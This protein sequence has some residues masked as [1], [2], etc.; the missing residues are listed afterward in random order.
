MPE[1]KNY[2]RILGILIF[3]RKNI[4]YK[5]EKRLFVIKLI[6]SDILNDAFERNVK[7]L[8]TTSAFLR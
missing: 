8:N 1:H 4:H 6:F 5:D 2:N 3:I 7:T